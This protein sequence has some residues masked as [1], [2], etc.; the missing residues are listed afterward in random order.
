MTVQYYLSFS[1]SLVFCP[2]Q[3]V[4]Y[5]LGSSSMVEQDQLLITAAQPVYREKWALGG[6]SGFEL[7]WSGQQIWLLAA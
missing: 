3:I 4:L 6:C 1:P 7:A 5:S 2:L